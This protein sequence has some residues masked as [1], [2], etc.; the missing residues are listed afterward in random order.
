M[1]FSPLYL[2]G[3]FVL[4]TCAGSLANLGIYRLAW[5]P[6]RIGPW[7]RPDQ[8]A[9]PRRWHDRLPIVGW[10]GLR[11]EAALHGRGFWIRPMLLELLCGIAFAA[12]YWWEIGRAGL[13]PPEVPRAL[14]A[15]WIAVLHCQYAAHLILIALMLVASAID[16]DEKIIPDAITM[17]GTLLGLLVACLLPSSLLPDVIPERGGMAL[18]FLHLASPHPWPPQLE[19]FPHAGS[20]AIGLGCWWLWCAALLP[21]TW[22]AR[23]GWRR[24]LQLCVARVVRQPATYRILVMGLV[25]TAG[26]AAVWRFGGLGWMGLLSALVGMAVGGGLIWMVRIIGSA[27][28]QK[29]AMGFGDVTL[30]AMIGAFLGWQ[31]CLV[32]FFIAPLA[33]LVVG[34]LQLILVRDNEIPYGPFLCLAAFVTIVFWAAIWERIWPIMALG[35]GWFVPL[36]VLACL[37]LM[38]IMLGLWHQ[39]VTRLFRR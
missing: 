13:L 34:L 23:H 6:R 15:D 11:R 32:V 14:P 18:D 33:G 10:L 1:P 27:A 37:G 17:P 38:G 8:K 28:L 3:L 4:G 36:I 20:L 22:Y 26:I 30:M 25:G 2:I 5:H 7:W 9:P 31:T 12:L 29:E 35:D 24:A 16:V 21:R 19:G 39:L